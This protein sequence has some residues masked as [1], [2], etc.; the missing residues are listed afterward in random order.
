MKKIILLLLS[1]ISCFA[2]QK[3]T[4]DITLTQNLGVIANFTLNNST[5]K[6]TLI[7]K[8]P[9]DR[10]F[11]MGIGVSAGF[12][13]AAPNDVVV[14]SDVTSPKLTDRNFIG[15]TQPAID[16]TQNWTIVSNLI[17]GSVRT[18]TLTRD[19]STGDSND[20]QMPYATTNSISIACVRPSSATQT[21]APHGGTANVGYAANVSFSTLGVEDFSLNASSVYPNPSSGDF[22]VS[23]KT[24]LNEINVYSHTGAFVQTIKVNNATKT[25][26]KVDGLQT[27]IYLLE[28]K[29]ET[30]KSWK[31]IIVE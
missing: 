5:S 1:S 13:M 21:V 22:T 25:N 7:L 26:V 17:Q 24:A 28:L 11:G 23:T 4:G 15:F 8:G 29:N 19:L 6:V 9:S 18:L 12:G 14:F 2:Q 30:D 31:K 27:G 20:Y 16:V 3:T 10:W